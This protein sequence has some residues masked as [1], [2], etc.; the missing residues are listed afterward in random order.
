MS[1][2]NTSPFELLAASIILFAAYASAGKRPFSMTLPQLMQQLTLATSQQVVGQ[3]P[4][5]GDEGL[6]EV[7]VIGWAGAAAALA[8]RRAGRRIEID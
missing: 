5:K 1:E 8:E 3:R 2:T 6:V 4:T 7:V